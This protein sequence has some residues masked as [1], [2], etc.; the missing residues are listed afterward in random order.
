[1]SELALQKVKFE[2]AEPETVL[3]SGEPHEG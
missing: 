1:V 2:Y 3:A